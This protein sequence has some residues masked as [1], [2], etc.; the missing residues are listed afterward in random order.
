LA[1]QVSLSSNIA[2]LMRSV[3]AQL[4]VGGA[5]VFLNLTPEHP[6]ISGIGV[7]GGG[8]AIA[9]NAWIAIYGID[10]APPSL[11]QGGMTWSAAPSFLSGLMPTV[12]DGVTVT[13]NGQPAYVYYVSGAQVNVLTPLDS[14]TGPVAVTVNNGTETSAAYTAHL[15]TVA[16]GILRFG[17]GVHVAA[18]H[19]NYN[20]VGPASW[21]VPGYTFAPAA[22][23]ETI[24]LY[25]DG[26]GLPASPLTAGSVEQQVALPTPW[27]SVIIGG[28][29]ASVSYAGLSSP[30]LYQLNVMVPSIAVNGDSEVLVFDKGFYSPA[31]AMITVAR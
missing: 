2:Q 28:V 27:P 3:L 1:L 5:D 11:G 7:S 17:D 9:Q 21:S 23:G 26:L 29:S 31:G 15:Q 14:T 19:A 20:Y 25:C 4:P 18:V 22:P 16:P 8:A 13:V 6:I 10:L 12:L 24:M 30:G